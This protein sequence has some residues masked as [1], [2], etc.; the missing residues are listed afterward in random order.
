M[1]ARGWEEGTRG[2]CYSMDTVSVGKALEVCCT[3]MCIEVAVLYYTLKVVKRVNFMLCV[4]FLQ[5]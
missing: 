1:V 3:K 4:F 5:Q 2:S